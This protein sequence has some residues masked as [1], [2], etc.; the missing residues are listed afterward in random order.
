[1]RHAC[2]SE[3]ARIIFCVVLWGAGSVLSAFAGER[4]RS[5]YDGASVVFEQAHLIKPHEG[6]NSGLATALAPL[7]VQEV[8][9]ANRATFATRVYFQFDIVQLNGQDHAALTYWWFYDEATK[10]AERRSPTRRGPD[11]RPLKR[12][13]AEAG[14]PIQGVRITLNTN[15]SPVIF[16][17]LGH[18]GRIEQIFVSQLLE[19]AALAEFGPALPGRRHSIER[20]LSDTPKIV[21]PRVIDDA[22]AVMGPILYLRAGTHDVATLICRCM[23]SQ[24]KSLA[25]QSFYEL[26]PAGA[27]SNTCDATRLEAANPRGLPR[28]F[29]LQTNR[30]SRSLRL[31][32]GF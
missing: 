32:A 28:D 31:P 23:D 1:M 2:Q 4:P 18:T 24:A 22:P 13:G 15:G 12:A 26:V 10:P 19:A 30:L 27:S 9:V 11:A 29:L 8:G 7:V 21:V 6:T 25:G 16:E 3:F 5:L 20:S 14:T 17:V